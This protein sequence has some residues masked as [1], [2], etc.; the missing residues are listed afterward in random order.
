MPR[1]R[2][3]DIGF[4][5]DI[6]LTRTKKPKWF[7]GADYFAYQLGVLKYAFEVADQSGV[8]LI[9]FG[10]DFMN[11]YNELDPI[12]YR[13]VVDLFQEFDH[14]KK[15]SLIG[16]HDILASDPESYPFSTLS[17]LNDK[18]DFV[19]SSTLTHLGKDFQIYLIDPL[20][21]YDD[22][23]DAL[24]AGVLEAKDHDLM[25]SGGVKILVAHAQIGPHA[26]QYCVGVDEIDLT[27]Y[28]FLLLGDQHQGW[29]PTRLPSGCVAVNPGA[30]SILYSD[31]LDRV[32]RM[33]LIK[34]KSVW[35][36][37]L[38]RPP[39]DK[40]KIAKVT[41]SFVR[42]TKKISK[43]KSKSSSELV[44]ETAKELSSSRKATECLL[45]EITDPAHSM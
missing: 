18:L 45:S 7:T 38:P 44:R 19:F 43:S 23:Q 5:T 8:S 16:N 3:A 34:G 29:S 6:H 13:G 27:G 40:D 32:P 42:N 9:L 25:R 2:P 20:H 26:T 36:V 39:H 1:M 37:D 33:S 35:E 30:M 15:K 28:D 41:K 4:I 10:G 17:V 14:I 24:M 22:R 21:W 12:L 31:E 11:R